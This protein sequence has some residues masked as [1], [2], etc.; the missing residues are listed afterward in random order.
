MKCHSASD[1]S[2]EPAMVL[3]QWYGRDKYQYA[4]PARWM[5]NPYAGKKTY[6][7]TD[8]YDFTI[9]IYEKEQFFFDDSAMETDPFAVQGEA[10][11]LNIPSSAFISRSTRFNPI[12]VGDINRQF[13]PF[14]T[15]VL[16]IF[17]PKLHD[18]S[19]GRN[20]CMANNVWVSLKFK[21][22]LTDRDTAADGAAGE[23]LVQNIPKNYGQRTA[24]SVTITEP[25]LPREP[26]HRRRPRHGSK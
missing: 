23:Q 5:P 14:K 22:L 11:S 20:H 9:S 24:P 19:T 7:R 3:D 26:R 15:Y 6:N 1:Q 12:A 4:P 13:D 16:A 21:M 8:A 10:V 2:D 18:V 17:A 25:A